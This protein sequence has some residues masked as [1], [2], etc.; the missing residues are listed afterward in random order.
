MPCHGIQAGSGYTYA[1]SGD[2]AKAEQI[3]HDL[4]QLAKRRY[5]TPNAWVPVYLGLGDNEKVLDG[6]EKCY[7]DQD[8]ACWWLKVDQVY[9]AIRNEP[10]FQTL[11]TNV[12][13]KG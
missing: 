13:L 2:R 11:L 7:Q 8:G 1:V 6:L 12:G 9:D 5:V 10:R 4:D 3:L